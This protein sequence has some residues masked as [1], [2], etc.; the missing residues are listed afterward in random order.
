MEQ[1]G[2]RRAI[3]SAYY[4]L[5][6]TLCQ[7]CGEGL[8]LWIAGGEDLEL[9]YRNLEHGRAKQVLDDKATKALH[10]D[11]VRIGEVFVQLRHLREDSDYSQPGRFGDQQKLLTRSETRTLIGIA[12]E[13]VGLIDGLPKEVRRRL[14]IL[15]TLRQSRRRTGQDIK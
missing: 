15:L 5:F 2:F 1:A 9:I 10:P 4:A 12:E 3:S 11:L 8:G 14:A 13:S 7:V 6:H